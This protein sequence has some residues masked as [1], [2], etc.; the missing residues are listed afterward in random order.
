MSYSF[1]HLVAGE[2]G[3]NG[4]LENLD[5]ERLCGVRSGDWTHVSRMHTV[6]GFEHY[7][8]CLDCFY[9]P[10]IPLYLLGDLP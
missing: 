8:K 5:A 7:T 10:D 4:V 1:I 9:H 6:T 3:R 2:D